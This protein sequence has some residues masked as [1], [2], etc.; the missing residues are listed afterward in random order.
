MPS[1]SVR[2][3]LSKTAATNPTALVSTGQAGWRWV[4]LPRVEIRA[5]DVYVRAYL[6]CDTS[7]NTDSAV[8]YDRAIMVVDDVPR[9]MP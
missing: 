2:G 9:D 4:V 8:Y 5:E 7:A 6:Y 1:G 3:C